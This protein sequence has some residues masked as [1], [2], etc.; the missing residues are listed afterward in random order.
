MKKLLGILSLIMITSAARAQN[1]PEF[2]VD[3]LLKRYSSADTLYIV[4]FFATWC[5]PCMKEMPEFDHM[6][7]AYK[8]KP[9]K[10]LLVS[11]DFPKD[12]PKKLVAFAKK[13]KLQHEL[14]WLNESDANYFIP[15]I[16]NRW[17]GSI[18]ATL[19]V[20]NK[21]EYKNFFEGMISAKQLQVLIDKQLAL[22]Y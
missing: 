17:Q 15:K 8:D 22:N 16:D 4:N 12:Y 7:D 18:P 13:R 10:V 6:A 2:K 3:D 14:M 19:I 11:V 21:T 1:I 20:N 5:G 9:V